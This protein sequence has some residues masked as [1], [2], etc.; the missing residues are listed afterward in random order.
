M[1]I[2]TAG[3]SGTCS[4]RVSRC[5]VIRVN[6][7][8][9]LTSFKLLSNHEF[10]MK[11]IFSSIKMYRISIN[12]TLNCYSEGSHFVFKIDKNYP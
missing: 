1:H 4:R 8:P 5:G 12:F 6:K 3:V 10:F 2:D 9:N 11:T 7:T